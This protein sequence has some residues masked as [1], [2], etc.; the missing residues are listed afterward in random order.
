MVQRM[1]VGLLVMPVLVL[2]LA[3]EPARAQGGPKG[4]SSKYALDVLSRKFGEDAFTDKTQKFGIEIYIDGNN[5]NAIYLSQVGALSTVPSGLFKV[6]GDKIKNPLWQHG[7]NLAVR[8]PGEKAFTKD[9]KR[10]GLEVLRDVNSGNLL[11][12]CETGTPAVVP[13]K[14]AVDTGKKIGN[15][16]WKS[17]LILKVRKAGEKGFSKD[18]KRVGVECFLDENNG[19]LI[20]ISETGSVSA[21]SSKLCAPAASGKDPEWQHGMELKARK[22]GE[23]DFKEDTKKYGIE[24]FR[25]PSTGNL[26]YLCETGDISVVPAKLTS[27]TAEG[28]T[29]APDFK[30]GLDLE[31]RKAGETKFSPSTKKY[32]MEIYADNNNGNTIYLTELGTLSVVPAKRE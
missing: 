4:A 31:S 2:A 20:Y 25:E 27:P 28:A 22:V 16:D 30:Y 29:K 12:V 19:T 26:I 6:E 23:N 13:G 15:P 10:Y 21:V 14:Y 18:T 17:S 32:A 1:L 7:L 5:G 9:T 3:Q 24:V 11:Y 8:K